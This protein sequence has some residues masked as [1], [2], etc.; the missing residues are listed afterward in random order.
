MRL[1]IL[2]GVI[3]ALCTVDPVVLSD[4]KVVRPQSDCQCEEIS[5]SICAL[6]FNSGE[7]RGR[8]PNSRNLDKTESIKE[9]FDFSRLLYL[10]NY[11]SHVLYNFLCF[12]YFPKCDTERPRLGATPCRETCNEVWTAC[13]DHARSLSANFTFPDHL[14]CSN[15]PLGSSEC[16]QSTGE[17]ED[18]NSQCTACPNASQ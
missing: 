3:V 16:S 8:F 12:H 11:C 4:V 18:C 13:I 17:V 14:Q 10:D 9:F 7:W 5:G 6:H 15:F 1:L 2:A